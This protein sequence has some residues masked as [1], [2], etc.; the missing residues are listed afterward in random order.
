MHRYKQWLRLDNTALMYP[1]IRGSRSPTVFRICIVTKSEVDPTILQN[2]VNDLL[3]RFPY[4]KMGLRYGFFWNFL[5]Q[6]IKTPKV[7]KEHQIPCLEFK[8]KEPLLRVLYYGKRISAEFS[9]ILTD[10]IGALT[11]TKSLICHYY[12][13]KGVNFSYPPDI[14]SVEEKPSLE[15]TED[16]YERYFPGKIPS[17]KKLSKA[18][19]IKGDLLP[20]GDLLVITGTCN[21]ESLI[22][23]CKK[24]K[25]SVTDYLVAHYLNSIYQLKGR[26]KRDIRLMVPIN[27]RT[28]YPSKTFRNFFLTTIVGIRPILGNYTYEEILKSVN[29]SLKIETDPKHLNQ[30]IA[31]NVSAARNIF[32]RLIPLFV[33]LPI[34]RFIFFRY[35][36][37]P[38][39]G[40]FSNLGQINLPEAISE[41]IEKIIFLTSPSHITKLTMGVAGFKDK[42]TITFTSLTDSTELPRLFFT[43]LRGRGI[44]TT[45]ESNKEAKWHTVQ[46]VE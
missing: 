13:L 34:E 41:N 1:A 33:K 3:I 28:I 15:E 25:V 30:Q 22:S 26:S 46:S 36:S 20:Y 14:P 16:A 4:F 23:E 18:F 6:S 39:S 5:E 32:L 29:L 42:I 17:P 2:S 21:A 11:F 27:L 44:I 7:E 40:I 12:R 19:H 24:L 9:H 37:G 38:V 10:G 43:S 45:I 8:A 35:G 31:R